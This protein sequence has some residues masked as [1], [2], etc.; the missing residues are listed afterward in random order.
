MGHGTDPEH[1]ALHPAQVISGSSDHITR[2][3]VTVMTDRSPLI[4]LNNGADIELIRPEEINWAFERVMNKDVRY[5]FIID[6]ASLK[7]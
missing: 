7:A 3:E 6:M 1:F 4:T 2:R 5:R